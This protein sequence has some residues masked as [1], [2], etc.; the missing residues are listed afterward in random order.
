ML[1]LF[2]AGL[3]LS[4]C[5]SRQPSDMMM[6]T[7]GCYSDKGE[8]ALSIYNFNAHDAS[9]EVLYDIPV[10]NASFLDISASGIIYAVSESGNSSR[11]T[12][13]RLNPDSLA[14]EILNSCPTNSADPCYVKVS[15]DGNFVITANYTGGTVTVFPINGDGSLGN[16]SR[17]LTFDFDEKG[18]VPERQEA[19]H[20]HCISFTPDGKWMLVDDLGSD[21]IHQYRVLSAEEGFIKSISDMEVRLRPGSGPRHI[22]FNQEGNRAYLI[23]ELS[24]QVTVLEY[25]GETLVPLQ[26]IAADTVGAGGAADIHLSPDGKHLYAS[27]RL[28]H[29][30]IACFDVNS[31]DGLLTYREHTSTSAHPRNFVITPDGRFLL[32]AC[33]DG[34]IIETYTIY[35]EDGSL[36][37]TSQFIS[38]PKPVYVNF[39]PTPVR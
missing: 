3:A 13:L 19:P 6:M 23:N 24:D 16:A 4:A 9:A 5:T 26:Y 38:I 17:T 12:A 11:L 8:N 36:S 28:K 27:L 21:A 29:D 14:A 39:Y 10:E 1:S 37:K 15:P 35:P 34:N 31:S 25:D 2:G 18:T 33:R 7:V 20:P 32:V 22:I 30:G